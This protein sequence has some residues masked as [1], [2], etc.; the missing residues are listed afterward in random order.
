M[1]FDRDTLALLYGTDE[2]TLSEQTAL[3]DALAERFHTLFP[4]RQSV[5]FFSASGRAEIGGNHT[6]HQLGRV[7]AA[8]IQLDS[9]AAVAPAEDMRVC[10]HSEGFAP[11]TLD[12]GDLSPKD[13]EKNTTAAV[14]RG[15]AARM[16][17]RGY[18]IGGF[19]AA[20]TSSVLVGSGLSSSAAFEVL[21]LTILDGLYNEGKMSPIQ[22]AEMAQYAENVYFGKPSGLMDQMASSVGGLVA[23]DFGGETPQVTPL[24]FDFASRRYAMAVVNTGGSHDDLTDAYAAI[25]WEMEQV[26]QYFG[27]EKLSRVD[28]AAFEDALPKLRGKVSDRALLRAYHFFDENARVPL[29]AEALRAGDL[30]GFLRLVLASGASSERL[31][32]NLWAHPEHQPLTLALELSRRMLEGRG[33]WRVHGG[34]FAGTILAF[35]PMDLLPAYRAKMDAVFGVGACKPL[36]VRTVGAYEVKIKS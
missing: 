7:L 17:A 24:Q 32:Q 26:A 28:P 12:L 9:I 3:Y 33:A 36:R 20:V 30:D 23:I 21:I 6:D 19:D 15:C 10:I 29:Q 27:E 18:K 1:T 11:L 14:V 31:L 13:G 4:D 35:I 5:R 22:R 2:E 8:A 16:A 34:G 25:R